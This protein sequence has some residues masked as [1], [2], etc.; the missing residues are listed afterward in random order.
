MDRIII[1]DDN[2]IQD[3]LNHFLEV[4]K[5]NI[6]LDSDF[7][8]LSSGKSS[9]VR[10]IIGRY[11]DKYKVKIQSKDN[12]HLF[13]INEIIFLEAK[14]EGTKLFLANNNSLL[15]DGRI[16]S[17]SEQ[18]KEHPFVAIHPDYL[19]NIHHVVRISNTEE[20]KIVVSTGESLP[21]SENNKQIIIKEIGKYFT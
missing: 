4:N 14:S 20:T 2:G 8:E 7:I 17:I 11:E 6:R 3:D 15:L 13:R 12:I 18:L 21:V 9:L 1:I 19:V 10:E 5:L 16:E